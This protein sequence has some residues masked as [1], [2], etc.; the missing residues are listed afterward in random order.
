MKTLKAATYLAIALHFARKVLQKSSP[1]KP[2]D[3][4]KPGVKEF[5]YFVKGNKLVIPY[6]MDGRGF[7]LLI[8]IPKE[9]YDDSA[10][11]T[12]YKNLELLL[13]DIYPFTKILGDGDSPLAWFICS[14]HEVGDLPVWTQENLESLDRILDYYNCRI[15]KSTTHRLNTGEFEETP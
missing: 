10:L 6:T 8:I 3:M 12:L 5:S 15:N 4:P 2:V 13:P 1:V 9:G 14:G 11:K 7:A